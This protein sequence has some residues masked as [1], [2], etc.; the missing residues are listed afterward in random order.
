M[1]ILAIAGSLREGS[2]NVRLLREARRLAP[3]G[4]E[5]IPWDGLRWMPPYDPGMDIDPAPVAVAALREA[6]AHADAVLIST[7]EY[8]GSTTGVLKNAL[9][10]ASRPWPGNALRN[11]PVAVL[12][13]SEGSFGGVWAQADVKKVLGIIGAR[14][15]DEGLA[16]PYAQDAFDQS[17]GLIEPVYR[18]NLVATVT[19][20]AVEGAKAP[21]RA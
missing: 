2:H 9:D 11:K 14:V 16:L 13:A 8:N 4:I 18:E 12:A 1:K 6:M 15:L 5:V 19:A 17:G 7:P 10:W 21:A 20:L 3:Q